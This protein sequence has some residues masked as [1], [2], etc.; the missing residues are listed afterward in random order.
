MALEISEKLS[1]QTPKEQLSFWQC[2]FSTKQR[3]NISFLN[4]FISK[5]HFKILNKKV[6]KKVAA[7][8]IRW[9]LRIPEW[10]KIFS[11]DY[12]KRFHQK[13]NC[14]DSSTALMKR[15]WVVTCP[16]MVRIKLSKSEAIWLL[17]LKPKNVLCARVI[18]VNNIYLFD[19][20]LYHGYNVNI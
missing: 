20:M 10:N 15:Q 9:N 14:T 7:G 11:T 3:K 18:I 16:R 1:I 2:N 19:I 5:H 6:R 13:A 4:S 8:S 17:S 12:L